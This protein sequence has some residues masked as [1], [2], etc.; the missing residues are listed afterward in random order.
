ML[1][2]ALLDERIACLFNSDD[3]QQCLAARPPSPNAAS[4]DA[5]A[6]EAGPA[7][8]K[9]P[10]S[11][12]SG[13]PKSTHGNDVKDKPNPLDSTKPKV[14]QW[15]SKDRFE[16]FRLLEG[17]VGIKTGF[18]P[19]V[20]QTMLAERYLR[21]RTPSPAVLLHLQV[22]LSYLQNEKLCV[23][24][25]T[26]MAFCLSFLAARLFVK[27]FFG[28]LRIIERQHMYDRALN[29]LLFKVIFVGAILEPRWEE[30]LIW[31][32]WF[33]IL[34]FLRV[35]SM[36]CRDRI[37][38]LSVTASIPRRVHVKI[39]TMLIMILISNVIWFVMCISVFRSMLLLLSFECFT[40]FL[41]TIQT[42]VK[43]TIHLN[44]LSRLGGPCETR[45]MI[46]YYT[47]FTTEVVIMTTTLGHYLHIMYLH[48]ISFSLI[49]IVLFL[50]MRSVFNNLR[51]K[52]VSHNAYR[53]ALANMQ[54]Q[55]PSA[56]EKQL[57]DY[58][59]DCAICRDGMTSAKVLPCGHIFHLY[60]IRSWLEHHSSCPTCRR[61]LST[62]TDSKP[63]SQHQPRRE[64]MAEGSNTSGGAIPLDDN[65][66]R[67]VGGPGQYSS[68][69]SSSSLSSSISST[70]TSSM[71]MSTAAPTSSSQGGH[72]LFAFNSEHQPWM[73]RLGFPRIRVEVTD[74]SPAEGRD[75][76]ADDVRRAIAE[77]LGMSLSSTPTAGLSAGSSPAMSPSPGRSGTSTP[78]GPLTP[79]YT[80]SS[81]AYASSHHGQGDST[82]LRRTN[83]SYGVSASNF[84]GEQAKGGVDR[85]A[86]EE[87]GDTAGGTCASPTC[88][89]LMGDI[90]S[91]SSIKAAPDVPTPVATVGSWCGAN[92]WG[93]L[94][95]DPNN[96]DL[97]TCFE[98]TVLLGIPAL[99]A[100]GAFVAK[101]YKY[102]RHGIPHHLGRTGLIYWPSQI[103]KMLAIFALIE[104]IA[105]TDS[106]PLSALFASGTLVL[107]WVLSLAL[108]HHA[109]IYEIRSSTEL[110]VFQLYSLM[111]SMVVLRTL[112]RRDQEQGQNPEQDYVGLNAFVHY[113][114]AVAVGFVFEAWPRGHTA[115]QTQSSANAHDK[116]NWFSRITFHY[117]QPVISLGFRRPLE[118]IDIKDTMPADIKTD[119][120]YGQ[121][122]RAWSTHR[123]KAE[124][125]GKSPSLAHVLA[126]TYWTD[127]VYIAALG[128]TNSTFKFVIPVLI[129]QIL[130]YLESG[131]TEENPEP[132]P[133][134][135]GVLLAILMFAAA[136][137]VSFL[138][139]QMFKSAQELGIQIRNGLVS[140]IYQ[141]ALKLSPS[142]RQKS[143]SVVNL[144]SIDTGKFSYSLI[145]IARSISIPYEIAVATVMLYRVLGWSVLVGLFVI[146]PLTPVQ[147]K[148]GEFF[149]NACDE[150]M[151]AK[152][153]RVGL[154]TEILSGI[155]ITKLY[156]WEE[157]FK[158][159]I[160]GYRDIEIKLLRK[161]GTVVSFLSL[162]FTCLPVFMC[163]VSLGVYSTVGGPGFT[164]GEINAQVIFVSISLFIL[165]NEPVGIMSIIFEARSSLRVACS[166][167]EKFLI[168][169][170]IDTDNVEREKSLPRDKRQPVIK[171]QNA[172]L[173]WA[174]EEDGPAEA[175][176]EENDDENDDEEPTET[177]PLLGS[178]SDNSNIAGAKAI[179]RD[180]VLKNINISIARGSLTA[181]VGRVGQGK[182]SLL[183]AIIGEM[184]KHEGV[185]RVCGSIAYVPQQAWIVH[186]SVRNNIVLG[187]PFDQAKYDHILEAS[188]LLPDLAILPAG[189]QT[190]IGERG[191]NLSGG[192]KQRVSLARAAYMDADI[193]LLDDP[194]SAVDAH[195]DQ[196]LWEKLVGPNGLLKDK[197]RVL[198]THGIHHLEQ[199][200]NIVVLKDGEVSE[201][202]QYSELMSHRKAFYQ[203]ITEYS[204]KHKRKH[205]HKDNAEVASDSTKNDQESAANGSS[206]SSSVSEDTVNE[207]ESNEKSGELVEEEEV[208][209]HIVG[210]DVALKYIQAIS[211]RVLNRFSSDM[212]D[213]D[214]VVPESLT[215]FLQFLYHSLAVIFVVTY[216]TPVFLLSLPPLILIY[217]ILQKYYLRTSSILR[218]IESVA[219]SPLYEHVGE[220]MNGR[221][222]IRAM[223][224]EQR[225]VRENNDRADQASN[226]QYTSIITNRWLHIRLEFL[227]A[228][229]MLITALLMVYGKGV[230]SAGMAGLAL[231]HTQYLSYNIIWLLRSYCDLQAELV[232]VERVLDYSRRPTEAPAVTGV[233]LADTWPRQGRVRFQNYSTRY[234][235]GLDLV[236]R[237]VSFEVQP[238][239]KI[240]IV[241]RTGAGKSSLTLALFRIIEA[242][243]SYWAKASED[244]Q[245]A[246][247][248]PKQTLSTGGNRLLVQDDE[249]IDGGSILV[250]GVDIST[251]GLTFLRQHLAI[252]P[253]DPTLFVGTLRENLDPFNEKPDADLWEALERAHLKDHINTLSDGLEHKVEQ[254]GENF[255]VGQ[256]SLICLAR[257]LLRQTKILV[258]DEATSS[259]D[260]ETDELIQRTIR[261][262][263]KDRTIL[264]IAHR[265]K[266][267]MDYDKI[268]VLEAGRV[269]EFAS[270]SALLSDDS[271]IFYSLALQAGEISK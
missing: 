37:D 66:D 244:P 130:Q 219:R 152:D 45:R 23:L 169:R 55:Y 85:V 238:G 225:F 155:K 8:S 119:N 150:K 143:S 220:S 101:M 47:E 147:A 50:N 90:S 15:S 149:D 170:E 51:K 151:A 165:L 92:G 4:K 246:L 224:L 271:T 221:S 173:A 21:F 222:S 3:W 103:A 172:T 206:D 167:V 168:L 122:Q 95:P 32:A 267:V 228:L 190:E 89:S 33:T 179:N 132:E 257:A 128:L 44:E 160:M 214:E 97:T 182:S 198:V 58:S 142:S 177:S 203:L 67:N 135:K 260:M 195:V 175:D 200:D 248:Q 247:E 63:S 144:V 263:F 35:F 39:Y 56:T 139:G 100:T 36:L 193:Y 207:S 209:D 30:L 93:P 189:D 161:V 72:Q 78:L 54:A 241:G 13:A 113:T 75:A 96:V 68:N 164:R 59:D 77:S 186:G 251:I 26:N 2:T 57:A 183:S 171:I 84:D 27:T 107:A 255:S 1:D 141:K 266:T 65:D 162:V 73:S 99:L 121:L 205:K 6:Q 29:F 19:S 106:W 249:S 252:I 71:G 230:L 232:S 235:Q 191:I 253:Q 185:I 110:Y 148:V 120:A 136:M 269:V 131:T 254:G 20:F 41:D 201:I 196:H 180:P 242:A 217:V 42:L 105:V 211:G 239:E 62:E 187:M 52:L 237:N 5:S 176:D 14:S 264:T 259:V 258:L 153:K 126:V 74:P 104:R 76:D 60:C 111:A 31:V 233:Q 94:D 197:T 127:W 83:A 49:D 199:V 123:A 192:Q 69:L 156:G 11:Q 16:Q 236:L 145:D 188:G 133:L 109:S 226:A 91:P 174:P 82:F 223:G 22:V 129:Q 262:E 125:K 243:N 231:T 114:I 53:R 9:T 157:S 87:K 10:Q 234:R 163:M 108:N 98:N 159:R 118:P 158:A 208:D 166:R 245:A 204:A 102:Q 88:T 112:Y 79:L 146:V 268:L 270:P 70:Q 218:R 194:L 64:T 250:D 86:W 265:I 140:M 7:P 12:P 116:A 43:Y 137:A 46:Q 154:M 181:V 124:A 25:F 18:R 202:G 184:Y 138:T 216:V 256:R 178:S 227:A 213:I 81:S 240:G 48:G 17:A 115:V 117:L 229:I 210:W 261:T 80:G 61:S 34:G 28:D 212:S 134:A 38:Y 40:L 215:A 24:V